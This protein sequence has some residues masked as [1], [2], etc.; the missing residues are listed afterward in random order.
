MKDPQEQT[1]HWRPFLWSAM[2]YGVAAISL[3]EITMLTICVLAITG[4]V[5]RLPWWPT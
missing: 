3:V 5:P 1:T 2:F 4:V